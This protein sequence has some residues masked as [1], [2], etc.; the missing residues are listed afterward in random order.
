VSLEGSA[1]G[2]TRFLIQIGNQIFLAS[3]IARPLE[4]VFRVYHILLLRASP[5]KGRMKDEG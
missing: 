1:L 5:A 3:T 4:I 2:G